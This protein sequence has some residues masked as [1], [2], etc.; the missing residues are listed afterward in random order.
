MTRTV[1]RNLSLLLKQKVLLVALLLCNP[2][3]ILQSR[4]TLF[5]LCASAL[6]MAAFQGRDEMFTALT[7][8]DSFLSY[9]SLTLNA[10]IPKDLQLHLTQSSRGSFQLVSGQASS[11]PFILFPSH[12][13]ILL[14]IPSQSS[15][16]YL[17]V[18][19][20]LELHGSDLD[21]EKPGSR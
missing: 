16:T 2:P 11:C 12:V 21:A 4:L 8:Q 9:N 20:P 5:T 13:F 15:V 19:F 17:R 6:G 10:L 1:G 14:F 18:A 3:G 7:P